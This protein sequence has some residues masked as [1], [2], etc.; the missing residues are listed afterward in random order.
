MTVKPVAYKKRAI[1]K[2]TQIKRKPSEVTGLSY[3]FLKLV[4][5]ALSSE[6]YSVEVCFLKIRLP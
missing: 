4:G 6:A 5:R 1:D 3:E 2:K